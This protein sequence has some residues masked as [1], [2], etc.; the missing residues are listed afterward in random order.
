MKLKVDG[1][2]CIFYLSSWSEN[3]KITNTFIP[4]SKTWFWNLK[5]QIAN[6]PSNETFIKRNKSFS[7]QVVEVKTSN[8]S[9]V[10]Y[11]ITDLHAS[12]NKKQ[13]TIDHSIIL[14]CKK[15]RISNI[16]YAPSL[17]SSFWRK[18]FGPY[19]LLN[20]WSLKQTFPRTLNFDSYI[21]QKLNWN[22]KIS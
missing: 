2:Y 17:D 18:E 22:T 7:V 1:K 9:Q 3:L 16:N 11:K 13:K 8:P 10:F 6:T 21:M 5:Q 14:P 4:Q 19:F 12:K 20:I 15:K